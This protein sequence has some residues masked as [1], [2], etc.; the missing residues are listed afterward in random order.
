M[1]KPSGFPCEERKSVIF[2]GGIMSSPGGITL[3]CCDEGPIRSTPFA[4]WSPLV[5]IGSSSGTVFVADEGLPPVFPLFFDMVLRTR[6]SLSRSAS[7]L[8][9]L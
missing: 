6:S 2:S 3:S 5:S 8:C 7:V 1:D 4:G 9:G